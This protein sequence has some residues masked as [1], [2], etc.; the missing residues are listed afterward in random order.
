M[1]VRVSLRQLFFYCCS[2]LFLVDLFTCFNSVDFFNVVILVSGCYLLISHTF[3]TYLC[4]EYSII[5]PN[6]LNSFNSFS[7]IIFSVALYLFCFDFIF[8]DSLYFYNQNFQ[9]IFLVVSLFILL[10]TRDFL[11]TNNVI[12]FE[13]DSLFLFVVF[14]SFCLC[15]ADD[16]L[17][18]YLAL[19]LQS[20]AFYVFAT[21]NRTSEFNTEA[22]LKYF[23]FGSIISC[24]LLLGFSFVYLTFGGTS[25]ELIFSMLTIKS[26]PFLF[27]GVVFILMAFLFKI[28]AVPFHWWLC[29][30]YDG[31]I[32]SVTALFAA[33]PKIIFFGI[34]VKMFFFIFF[35][36]SSIWLTL[37]LMSSVLSIGVGSISAIYQK[38]TK[39]LFAYSTISHTGFILLG[40]LTLSPDSFKS[41]VFYVIA[42]AFLTLLLFSVLV[43]SSISS[44][45]SILYITNWVSFGFKNYF[46]AFCFTLTLFSIAGIPP[47]LG[48]FSKFLV[49]LST[50][51]N[52]YYIT[53]IIVILLSSVSCFYYIRFIKNFFFVKTAKY[54]FWISN[55]SKQN[56]EFILAFCLFI[57]I[58][59]FMYPNLLSN[60]ST[61]IGLALF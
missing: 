29:D 25:F 30:V 15:F 37:F 13:Y 7:V 20:L 49:L 57:N 50:I 52:E 53:A 46:F 54:G 6:F 4:S 27:I 47:L 17:I 10:I 9:I 44:N 34:I 26:E 39:R 41:L 11:D 19:E 3:G 28:G 33:M 45:R 43:Y 61:I 12:R 59:F 14:S 31:S 32:L 40:I 5:T 36:L 1:R 22:G 35:D 51:S 16:L 23:I 18:I 48:F 21:F 42:Y 60:F 8:Y 38:R 55:S 2:V 56:T 58:C 24:F